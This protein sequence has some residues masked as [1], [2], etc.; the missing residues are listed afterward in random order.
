MGQRRQSQR[1]C[2]ALPCA[3][4]GKEQGSRLHVRSTS[5]HSLSQ[6]AEVARWRLTQ[7]LRNIVMKAVTES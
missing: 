4:T 3:E 5:R 2:A 1:A 6:V 7:R